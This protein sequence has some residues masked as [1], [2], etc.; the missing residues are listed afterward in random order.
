MFMSPCGSL[1]A[2]VPS[3]YAA[4]KW[5]AISPCPPFACP[6][7]QNPSMTVWTEPPARQRVEDG[8][9]LVG[10]VAARGA[11]DACAEEGRLLTTLSHNPPRRKAGRTR[12]TG[13]ERCCIGASGASPG[14]R[15]GSV[16]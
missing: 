3:A 8:G 6:P 5:R 7:R 16:S 2:F 4:S 13:S 10:H 12:G 14:R 11:G 9:L 1:G 15:R